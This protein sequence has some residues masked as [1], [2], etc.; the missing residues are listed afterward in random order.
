MKNVIL[1]TLATAT[2]VTALNTSAD[3]G[4][5]W[6]PADTY[7]PSPLT[8]LT[9][10]GSVK[11]LNK[12]AKSVSS[13]PV[14]ATSKQLFE[15]IKTTSFFG[16]EFV[17]G[18]HYQLKHY[19]VFNREIKVDNIAAMHSIAKKPLLVKAR[20]AVIQHC[21]MSNLDLPRTHNKVTYT[22]KSVGAFIPTRLHKQSVGK[23]TKA[24]K[25]K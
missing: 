11:K 13:V 12:R 19:G 14:F 17:E 20:K 23:K 6:K 5:E 2:I 15:Y 1:Y 25:G 9:S 7:V 8:D 22:F 4:L 16:W 18:R 10:K 24:K 21:L 3:V